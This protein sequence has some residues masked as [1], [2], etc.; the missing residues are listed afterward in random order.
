M[1]TWPTYAENG[2]AQTKPGAW[3]E[4]GAFSLQHAVQTR[5]S[6]WRIALPFTAASAVARG[7]PVACR[8]GGWCRGIS[9]RPGTG[10]LVGGAGLSAL[11]AMMMASWASDG[12][13]VARC[14]HRGRRNVA[15]RVSPAIVMTSRR[16]KKTP[17][18][19]IGC[20]SFPCLSN[21]LQSVTLSRISFYAYHQR[22]PPK[23]SPVFRKARSCN[24]SILLFAAGK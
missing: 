8:D 17:G 20:R 10:V 3:R 7:G 14:C 9:S 19:A 2:R 4:C 24:R 1:G 21:T 16:N 6:S 11:K 13:R 5:S 15:R 22:N 18:V 12:K 23:V